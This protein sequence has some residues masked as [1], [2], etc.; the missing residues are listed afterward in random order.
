MR[1]KTEK[2]ENNEVKEK[3]STKKKTKKKI[4]RFVRRKKKEENNESF[5]LSHV[6][7]LLGIILVIA[8][9][10]VIACFTINSY[11]ANTKKNEY[12]KTVKDVIS[13]AQDKISTTKMEMYD[14]NTTYYNTIMLP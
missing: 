4:T 1:K 14:L 13:D 12:I 9:I 2:K 5:K 6:W 10:V 3:K 8:L 11:I 7:E